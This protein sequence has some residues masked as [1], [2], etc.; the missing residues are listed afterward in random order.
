MSTSC[1]AHP[2]PRL[3]P[4]SSSAMRCLSCRAR[5]TCQCRRL[6]SVACL[7]ISGAPCCRRWC[8][9]PADHGTGTGPGIRGAEPSHAARSAIS[10]FS[11]GRTHPRSL[12]GVRRQRLC[13]RCCVPGDV[14]QCDVARRRARPRRCPAHG[15]APSAQALV[16]RLLPARA[17]TY[18]WHGRSSAL[19]DEELHQTHGCPLI[20]CGLTRARCSICT[21]YRQYPW[22]ALNRPHCSRG[23]CERGR[24]L[25][26]VCGALGPARERQA[27]CSLRLKGVPCALGRGARRVVWGAEVCAWVRESCAYGVV[28]PQGRR[29]RLCGSSSGSR[30]LCAARV[31]GM[32]AL[33]RDAGGITGAMQAVNEKRIPRGAYPDAHFISADRI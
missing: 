28:C 23:A 19:G 29:A 25:L 5:Q 18:V 9:M 2:V 13:C 11:D 4:R 16:F 31:G 10:L 33:G 3:T 17:Q 32:S 8:F 27:R 24:A 26:C 7:C 1:R 15:G 21:L 20:D 14:L 30:F 22:A 12:V 6:S